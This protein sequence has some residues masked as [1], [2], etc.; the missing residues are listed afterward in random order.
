MLHKLGHVHHSFCYNEAVWQRT[1]YKNDDVHHSYTSIRLGFLASLT[2]F[3]NVQSCTVGSA[4]LL[5]L[6]TIWFNEL[7]ILLEWKARHS[8]GIGLSLPRWTNLWRGLAT[9]KV[10][11]LVCSWESMGEEI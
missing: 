11:V 5:D 3:V 1:D 2:P 7:N 10:L 6:C 8:L 9:N 4:L